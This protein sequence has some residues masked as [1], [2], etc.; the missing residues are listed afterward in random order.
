MGAGGVNWLVCQE[1][2]EVVTRH[3]AQDP[4]KTA[5][6]LIGVLHD[7]PPNLSVALSFPVLHTAFC[8]QLHFGQ[9]PG[10]D[11][12]AVG[13]H[14]LYLTYVIDGLPIN[15]GMSARGIVGD[16]AANGCAVRRG[17]IRR[18]L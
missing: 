12:A 10:F 14:D 13:Q 16:H 18:E 5:L 11:H 17:K 15:D 7:K 1:Q 6:D 8:F 3:A 2:I 9:D 4:G